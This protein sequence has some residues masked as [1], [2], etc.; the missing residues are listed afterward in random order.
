MQ[1]FKAEKTKS[2]L[3]LYRDLEDA[4]RTITSTTGALKSIIFPCRSF[5]ELMGGAE[6]FDNFTQKQGINMV[7]GKLVLDAKTI[8]KLFQLTIDNILTNIDSALIFS[9]S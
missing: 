4:K 3:K 2:Y 7:E 1:K 6:Q 9:Q 5:H 8:K